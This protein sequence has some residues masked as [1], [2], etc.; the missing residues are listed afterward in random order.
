MTPTFNPETVS[1]DEILE[2]RFTLC[3][4][5]GHVEEVNESGLLK[6]RSR[7]DALLAPPS[8]EIAD[9]E[10]ICGSCARAYGIDVRDL[11]YGGRVEMFAFPRQ[12]AMYLIRDCSSMSFHR[13]GSYFRKDHGT[14]IHA[15]QLVA[16]RL[17]TR[18]DIQQKIEA[19]R[20][21]LKESKIAT[22]NENKMQ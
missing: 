4:P 16:G 9:L 18:L 5:S 1:I 22:H 10:I 3:L 21:S 11:K 17:E 2:R 20:K 7:I 19:I 13:I 12:V 8:Y 6:L 14:V 15:C